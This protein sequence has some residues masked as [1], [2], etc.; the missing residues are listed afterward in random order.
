MTSS[1]HFGV[2]PT[3]GNTVRL[4]VTTTK[5]WSCSINKWGRS[6]TIALYLH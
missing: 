1:I 3:I 2:K 6:F 5:D 4:A